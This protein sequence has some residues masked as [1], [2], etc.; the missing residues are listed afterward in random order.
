MQAVRKLYWVMCLAMA[1]AAAQ[2]D[3]MGGAS[4][5]VVQDV[6]GYNSW[7]MI[8]ALGDDLVCAYS[9]GSAHSIDEGV[10][11]VYARVSSD[12]GATWGAETCIANDASVGEVT[13]GKGLDESGAMLLWVRCA[14]QGTRHDLY[15]TTDGAT[16]QKIATPSLSPM[17]IQITDVFH[18]PGAGMM[19]L[20]FAGDY[21]DTTNKSWGVMTSSDNGLTWAQRTVESNLAKPDWPTEQSAAY[22]GNG[23][24]L[25][26]AR[27]EGAGY[28]FQITSADGGATWTRVRTNI[29]DVQSSTPSLLLDPATG[30]LANYYYHRGA[31]KLKRRVADANWIFAHPKEWP[32]P[33]VL[34]EGHEERAH[35]AGNVNATAIGSRHHL[36]T[37][38]GTEADTSVVAVSVP[39]PTRRRPAR[40]LWYRL[41]GFAPGVKTTSS[42]R[43]DNLADPGNNQ[44]SCHSYIGSQRGTSAEW[45]P[46]GVAGLGGT[47]GVF[48]PL[49]GTLHAREHALH[50]GLDEVSAG[51][52][53]GNGGMLRL[54]NGLALSNVTVEAIYRLSP[55][56]Y[57]SWRMA[58]I[59]MQEGQN[60]AREGWLLSACGWT[61][62][63]SARFEHCAQDGSGQAS[64]NMQGGTYSAAQWH[65]A[66]FTFDESG[67]TRLY[68]DY[69][70][71]ATKTHPG[72][73]LATY[74]SAMTIA[75]NNG[76]ANRTFPGDILEVRISD[77]A[78]PPSD[79]LRI[80][81][82]CRP[83]ADAETVVHVPF[84]AAGTALGAG[85]VDMNAV[86][87]APFAA[88]FVAGAN[89]PDGDASAVE[90]AA[91][92]FRDGIG[93]T[94][95]VANAAA[96]FLPTNGVREGSCL[97]ID[98][99]NAML[100][101]ESATLEC[102]FKTP[103]EIRT[104]DT[105]VLFHT[106][107][108]KLFISDSGA[109]AGKIW[110]RTFATNGVYAS[111]VDFVEGERVDDGAWHHVAYV[112][113]KS[114]GT[115]GV[116]VDHESKG[117]ANIRP[118]FNVANS[119][120]YVGR[121]PVGG[122]SQFFPGWL[123]EVRI[124]RRALR[125][126]E[127]LSVHPVPPRPETLAHAA[128][129]GNYSLTPYPSLAPDGT[130]L[131][132]EGGSEPFFDTSV[133]GDV[134]LDGEG[135]TDVRRNTH[136]LRMDGSQVRFPRLG[137]LERQSFTVECFAKIA[138]ADLG[139]GFLR[140]NRTDE[141][142]EGNVLSPR[143][144]LY[145]DPGNARRMCCRFE[146]TAGYKVATFD[147][148]PAEFADGKWHHW[149]ITFGSH[150]TDGGTEQTVAEL[151]RDYTSYGR[152][153]VT[154]TMVIN[155]PRNFSFTVGA[156]NNLTGWVDELRFS[157]G[158]LPSAA[159]MR[160]RPRGG[161]VI[162]R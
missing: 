112:Y 131:A 105:W 76:T 57:E 137:A 15:R 9:R 161:V 127:F 152:K 157:E 149:A 50:F 61:G 75:A 38:T 128:L 79:F 124:T 80:R 35:D 99:A 55:G 2:M 28:Q 138:A 58:P 66:A 70:L 41:D 8:Q 162:F 87:N 109:R 88:H 154:G 156:N 3:P 111:A 68:L 40:M 104:G 23:H 22:L 119:C 153:A 73:R 20:W 123:D 59:V 25:V 60:A 160:I 90:K 141:Y 78:L 17:P 103:G 19:C 45:M 11:G 159:F 82:S 110:A 100:F 132:R 146:T 67:T 72:R 43:I 81:E 5:A 148:L 1:S 84:S 37:Y 101:S 54:L 92:A 71:K 65:H 62:Q 30:T 97:R 145:L 130:G 136:S 91:E 102:V 7:P 44:L 150:I 89:V 96:V 139:V 6:A 142:Y 83:V 147:A 135:G 47:L 77:V 114:S 126:W 64:D 56:D 32:E 34:A 4:V 13:I 106:P 93:S 95:P 94:N 140:Q 18:V 121:Q 21:T 14:G 48:D 63:V 39:E 115:A 24:I 36:A 51:T 12:G 116:Y 118:C 98:D 85:I 133:P 113:D 129:D 120:M 16:F 134:I 42:T 107:A 27:S 49:T 158:I 33:D 143:W 31:K 74:T 151:W 10:R 52:A 144:M 26:V 46:R 155:P 108:L 69:E 86:S 125:P 117:Y 29:T 53:D 122:N